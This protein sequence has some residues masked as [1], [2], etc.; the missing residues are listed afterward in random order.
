MLTGYNKMN[1]AQYLQPASLKQKK[2]DMWPLL[3]LSP[4]FRTQTA[5]IIQAVEPHFRRPS[6]LFLVSEKEQGK[7]LF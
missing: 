6:N 2:R 7:Q 1:R 4:P 5:A 3:P